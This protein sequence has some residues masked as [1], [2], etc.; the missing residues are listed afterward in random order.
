VREQVS[1]SESKASEDPIVGEREGP[2]GL[3]VY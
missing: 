1:R 2:A 3:G